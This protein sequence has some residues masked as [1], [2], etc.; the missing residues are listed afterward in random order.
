[1]EIPLQ[2]IF[3]FMAHS[4]INTGHSSSTPSEGQQAGEVQN[5]TANSLITQIYH[6]LSPKAHIDS[7]FTHAHF[8][9]LF[10]L[11]GVLHGKPRTA[12]QQGV[13]ST[14]CIC[15]QLCFM[16]EMQMLGNTK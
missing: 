13:I 8:N 2:G 15:M 14:C 6:E 16:H 7:Q 11:S 3:N 12:L 1:M 10:E 4:F 5:H 9:T